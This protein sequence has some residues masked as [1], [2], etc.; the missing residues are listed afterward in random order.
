MAVKNG[1]RYRVVE[2]DLLDNAA[3]YP[4][5][6][7][8]KLLC[9]CV[10][11]QKKDPLHIVRIRP[12]L[13]LTLPRSEVSQVIKQE[14]DGALL[15]FLDV[16]I[17]G[18]YGHGSPLP[19][20]FTE[21]LIQDDLK[22]NNNARL[23][24]DLLHQRLYQLLYQVRTRQLPQFN[25]EDKNALYQFMFSMVGFRDEAW[26]STFP[27]PAFILRNI[28]IFRH[29]KGSAA[30][31][32]LLMKKLFSQSQVRIQ[33]CHQRW[34]HIPRQQRLGLGQQAHQLGE[35]TLL[36][37]KMKE[38]QAKVVV[39]ISPVSPKEYDYWVNSQ[40]HW[41]GLKSLLHYFI[42]QPLIIELN[43]EIEYASKF[44]MNLGKETSFVLGR[45]TWLLGSLDSQNKTAKEE[46]ATLAASL[47]LL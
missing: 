25:L 34:F 17:A 24:L 37:S 33:Q 45:N 40:K 44:R 27:D 21:E 43:M 42:G 19:K 39:H 30:G 32:R 18:I 20:F 5:I 13:G 14:R 8:Y 16:N 11:A 4:F 41:R 46:P 28:N 9:E 26:L 1:H 47:R 38:A 6:Q 12:V 10:L 7:A 23:F 3:R 15:Y 22:E 31:L 35:S 29:Q 36:G 2:Q